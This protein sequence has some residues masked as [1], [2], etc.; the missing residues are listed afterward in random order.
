MRQRI[1]RA[2]DE[3]ACDPRPAQSQ[4]LDTTDLEV[5]Q[6]VEIRRLR[7][8]PWRII[9]GVNDT[10]GWVWILAVRQRPPYDY[11]DLDELITSLK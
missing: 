1:K 10:E 11:N 2:I 8:Q 5:P 7:L 9:Y 6:N 3:L 4:P